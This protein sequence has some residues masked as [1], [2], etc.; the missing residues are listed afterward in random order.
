LSR[1]KQSKLEITTRADTKK[2]MAQP[3][4]AMSAR[5]AELNLNSARIPEPPSASMSGKVE[6]VI[7]SPRKSQPEKAQI[8]VD[9][10]EKHR[11]RDLRIENELTD[12]HGREVK[13]KKGAQVEVTVTSKPA[14][15]RK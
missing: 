10:P 5:I 2:E 15:P 1:R 3:R 11:Y 8:A 9:L 7:P 12:E 13:L 6:K 14:S 4:M